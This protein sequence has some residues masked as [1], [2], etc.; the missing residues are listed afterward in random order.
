[1]QWP[2]KSLPHL[3]AALQVCSAVSGDTMM[4][5]TSLMEGGL[6]HLS[7]AVQVCSRMS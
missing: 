3:P 7:A 5:T 4:G 6:A 1:M 2:G